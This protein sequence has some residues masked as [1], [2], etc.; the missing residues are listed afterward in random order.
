[1]VEKVTLKNQEKKKKNIGNIGLFDQIHCGI[2]HDTWIMCLS[3]NMA[4]IRPHSLK[5]LANMPLL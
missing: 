3:W 4:N 5:Y 1:M 2:I